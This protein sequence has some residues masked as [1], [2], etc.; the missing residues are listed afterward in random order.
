MGPAAA[1]GLFEGSVAIQASNATLNSDRNRFSAI[2]I[3]SWLPSRYAVN[4]ALNVVESRSLV[5]MASR[6]ARFA[7][8]RAA[9]ALARSSRD[10]LLH[11]AEE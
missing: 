6:L 1:S 4:Q 2:A 10:S 9:D 5:A 11:F 3:P 7:S 8:L